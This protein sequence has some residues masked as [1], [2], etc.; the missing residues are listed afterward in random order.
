M[1]KSILVILVFYL[2]SS[3]LLAQETEVIANEEEVI[4]KEEVV[5]DIW[6]V[7]DRLRLSVYKK[8][9]AKSGVLQQLNS[10]DRLG[11]L[12]ISGNYALV[13]TP[14]GKQGWVK[15]GFLV[16]SPTA[17]LLLEEEKKKTSLLSEEIKKLANSKQVIDQ[18]EIDMDALTANIRTL[19][20]E[21]TQARQIIVELKQVAQKK[22][23][24]EAAKAMSLGASKASPLEVLRTIAISYWRYLVPILVL[25]ILVGFL[26]AK[27]FIELRIRRRFHGLKVW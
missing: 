6:Y 14:D 10:G 18:Y 25:S 19:E 20:N 16:P 26:M 24:M 7:T 15:R 11:V 17:I 22:A 3:N 21:N 13:N 4:A 27:L 5:M 1:K 23:E 2:T 12:Q 8:A 9:N